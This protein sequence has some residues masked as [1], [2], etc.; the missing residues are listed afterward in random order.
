MART[1]LSATKMEATDY[2]VTVDQVPLHQNAYQKI[3]FY[4]IATVR[5]S[6]L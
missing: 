6:D 4:L 3:A 1:H 2:S 5:M